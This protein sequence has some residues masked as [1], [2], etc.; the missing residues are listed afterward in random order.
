MQLIQL[1]LAYSYCEQ[2]DDL[3]PFALFATFAAIL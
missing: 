2:S 1:G 3:R